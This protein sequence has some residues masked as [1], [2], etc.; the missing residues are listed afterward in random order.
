MYWL[1]LCMVGVQPYLDMW[2]PL[3]LVL[4]HGDGVRCIHLLPLV[5]SSSFHCIAL[6]ATCFTCHL[7]ISCISCTFLSPGEVDHFHHCYLYKAAGY[8]SEWVLFVVLL[9]VYGYD[10]LLRNSWV[11]SS[12]IRHSPKMWYLDNTH[13]KPNVDLPKDG[14]SWQDAVQRCVNLTAHMTKTQLWCNHS[15]IMKPAEKC[16][17]YA[18]WLLTFDSSGWGCSL[19]LVTKTLCQV[20][21]NFLLLYL[22]NK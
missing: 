8:S 19:I 14:S 17:I 10:V 4:Y 20:H 7:Y 16:P 21:L 9:A 15:C 13:D 18:R 5:L 11:T 12:S 22:P 1:H 3:A 6:L 2:F